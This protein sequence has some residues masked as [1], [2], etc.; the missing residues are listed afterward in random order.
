MQSSGRVSGANRAANG[1]NVQA[2]GKSTHLLVTHIEAL[3]KNGHDDFSPFL[4]LGLGRG[5]FL[6]I[7]WNTQYYSFDYCRVL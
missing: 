7:P 6:L 5:G 3:L 2:L 4:F 1:A